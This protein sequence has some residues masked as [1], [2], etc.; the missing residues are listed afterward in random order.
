MADIHIVILLATGIVAGFASGLLGIGGGFIMTPAQYLVF[1]DMGL[2]V[3]MA[4]KMA[5][6]T[7]LMVILPTALRARLK[8]AG[9]SRRLHR[10]TPPP[11]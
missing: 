8:V 9:W 5:F 2:T 7:T 4:I 3:D 10:S 11:S 6:G 1:A